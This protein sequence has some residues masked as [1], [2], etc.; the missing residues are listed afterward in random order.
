MNKFWVGHIQSSA[1]FCYKAVVTSN[2]C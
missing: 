2:H 1:H